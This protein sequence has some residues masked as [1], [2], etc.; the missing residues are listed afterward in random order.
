M[1]LYIKKDQD[2]IV[3]PPDKGDK[4]I[5]MSYT[6]SEETK[7]AEEDASG[8]LENSTYLEKLGGRI[9]GHVKG[10]EDPA[11]KHEKAIK[12]ALTKMWQVGQQ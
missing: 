11:I 12:T 2:R 7:S 3:I 1:C 9:E 8:I 4:S 5:V 10:D 6:G